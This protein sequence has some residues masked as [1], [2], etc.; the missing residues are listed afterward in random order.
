MEKRFYSRQLGPFS[1]YKC[2]VMNGR[3]Y[4]FEL[5]RWLTANPGKRFGYCKVRMVK[6]DGTPKVYGVHEVVMSAMMGVEVSWWR[7]QTPKLEVN[8]INEKKPITK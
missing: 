3:I 8:H 7:N 5:G 6:D 2:D 4:S 1:N